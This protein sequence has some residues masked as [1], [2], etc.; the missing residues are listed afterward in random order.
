VQNKVKY[1]GVD[2]PIQRLKLRL[3]Q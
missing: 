2:K 3:H 1:E